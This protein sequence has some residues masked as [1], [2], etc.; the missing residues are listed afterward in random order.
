M[1]EFGRVG[2]N[3][4]PYTVAI[5]ARGRITASDT[6]LVRIRTSRLDVATVR[7][8]I[9]LADASRFWQ[10]TERGG[11][12]RLPDVASEFLAMHASCRRHRVAWGDRSANPRV[13]ELAAVVRDLALL[14]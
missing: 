6:T 12:S 5:D 8:L 9:H 11:R 13:A 2:G 10:A 3:I 7:A 4:R 1:I 14:P